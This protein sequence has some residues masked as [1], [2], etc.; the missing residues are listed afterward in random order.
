M[1]FVAAAEQQYFSVLCLPHTFGQSGDISLVILHGMLDV[2]LEFF[3]LAFA[4]RT[5]SSKRMII[6]RLRIADP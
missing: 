5:D 4:G 2:V 6:G 3:K 1:R